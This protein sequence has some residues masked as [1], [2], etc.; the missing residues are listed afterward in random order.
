MYTYMY[1]N[2]PPKGAPFGGGPPA[3]YDPG[4]VVNVDG[5][6]RDVLC[7]FVYEQLQ[8]PILLHSRS[9]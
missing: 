5:P 1:T 2:Q 9:S 4:I 8:C 3:V 7:R 6:S